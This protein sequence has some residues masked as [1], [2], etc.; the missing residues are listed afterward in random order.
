MHIRNP[1]IIFIVLIVS[2]CVSKP[3]Q[4]APVN[5]PDTQLL[6]NLPDDISYYI[7]SP[8]GDDAN[9]GTVEFPWRTFEYA[10]SQLKPGDTLYIRGGV[11]NQILNITCSG[12]V[13][14]P[15]Y[16]QG[17]PGEHVI[18]DGRNI[19]IENSKWEMF[20]G[21]VDISNQ[22]NIVLSNIDVRNSQYTGV[23]VYE[24]ENITVEDIYTENTFSSGIG[25]WFCKNVSINHNEVVLACNGGSQECI[26]VSQTDG[27]RI[28]GNIVRDGGLGE[29]GGEGIDA[30]DGSRNGAIIGNEV[31]NLSRVGIYVESWNTH[32]YNI[33]VY[34]NLV[35]HVA[36]WGVCIAAENGGL[37][38][39]V[40]VYNNIIYKNQVGLGV[41]GDEWG[42]PGAQHPM[43]DIY[44]Y[45]N[46]IV[47]NGMNFWG[48]G[49]HLNCDETENLYIANNV[50]ADNPTAQI[51]VEE[52]GM[53]QNLTFSYN[54]I[55]GNTRND[56]L[57]NRNELVNIN[58]GNNFELVGNVEFR[59][60][61]TYFPP[62]DFY[63][64]MR[65]ET[66]FRPG[67]VE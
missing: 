14:Y 55:D 4:D 5:L 54:Y 36:A 22:V 31:Y 58:I 34:N 1:I 9:P 61:E 43:R 20:R 33:E 49:I 37:L 52:G 10:F 63:G 46:T 47:R 25:A 8:Y 24:C 41:E 13:D 64:N 53:P 48:F 17:A 6:M 42:E 16:I 23:M 2:S 3:V 32:T 19:K 38:E 12:S 51:F 11:Y 26:S 29:F 50:I 57:D 67:A 18:F 7:I 15:I 56:Y 21:L 45:N 39:N 59:V 62:I 65:N 35:H 60:D 66:S 44:I 40:R 28:E 30:K 27:F